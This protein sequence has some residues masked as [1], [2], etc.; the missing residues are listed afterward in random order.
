MKKIFT[1]LALT[2][3]FSM[4]AQITTE[5]TDNSGISASAIGFLTTSGDYSTAIGYK[6]TASG[7]YST[8]IG[9]SGDGEGSA[10]M[11]KWILLSCNKWF[12]NLWGLA[13]TPLELGQQLWV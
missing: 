7:Q 8:A 3:S 1:F 9:S 10:Q 12:C 11:L 4:N 2:I 5:G 6:T 13:P